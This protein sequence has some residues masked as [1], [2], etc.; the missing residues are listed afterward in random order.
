VTFC[1]GEVAFNHYII[2][3]SVIIN[4]GELPGMVIVL[5]Q[6]DLAETYVMPWVDL[7]KGTMARRA[8]ATH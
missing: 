6:S 1:S 3:Y 7:H 2:L 4:T 5:W 8:R